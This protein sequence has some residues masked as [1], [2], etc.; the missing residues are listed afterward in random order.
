MTSKIETCVVRTAL[1]AFRVTAS[2]Y[3]V[4]AVEPVPDP[5]SEPAAPA[6]EPARVAAAAL[7]AYASARTAPANVPLDLQGTPFQRAVWSRLVALPVGTTITYGALAAA[8]GI[9]GEAQRVGEAVGANPVCV[10]VPCHRVVGADGTLKGFRW[11]LELK[12]R[13]LA[14]EGSSALS[15]F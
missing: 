14:H 15:L 4:R 10:L 2:E 12:R 9:P 7:A 1:G 3:G 8:L 13:L 11:G 5:A 6:L